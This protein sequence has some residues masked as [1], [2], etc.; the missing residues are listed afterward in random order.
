MEIT[1][2]KLLQGK[3]TKINEK[4]FLSTKEYVEPF[5]EKMKQFTSNFRIEAISP[6]QITYNSDGED[7]TYNRVLVQAILPTQVDN[8]NEIYAL[9][10]SLDIRKPVYKIYRAMFE[11]TT[12]ITVVF[13]PN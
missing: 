6:N 5:L 1:L 7:I 3:S 9:A 2:E 10:Y 8:Y 12:N 4:D 13:D 11:N